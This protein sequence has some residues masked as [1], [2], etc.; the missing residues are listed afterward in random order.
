MN[1]STPTTT[2]LAVRL[3]FVLGAALATA[4]PV[5]AQQTPIVLARNVGTPDVVLIDQGTIYW[6]DFVTGQIRSVSKQPGG[7]VTLYPAVMRSGGDLAQD[8]ASLYFIG[9][10]EADFT[11]PLI[12][13]SKVGGLAITFG[14]AQGQSRLAMRPSGGTVYYE[15]VRRDIPHATPPGK[16]VAQWPTGVIAARAAAGGD[17][18]ALLW[19]S[20]FLAADQRAA[21]EA[22]A[23]NYA[24]W[25]FFN[26]PVTDNTYLYWV[27]SELAS[28]IWRMPL[29][30]GP[31]APFISGRA[32]PSAIVAPTQGAAAG[33]LFWLELDPQLTFNRIMRRNVGGQI[34]MLIDRVD[35]NF[36]VD[37]DQIFCEQ[38]GRLMQV[39]IDGGTPT[40][41]A[42][43]SVAHA[44]QAIAV[45]A[46]YVYWSTWTT[47]EIM[48]LP[49]SGS[50]GTGGDGPAAPVIIVHPASQSAA[51]GAN[52]SFT[53]AATGN[54]A[55]TF[56]WQTASSGGAFGEIAGATSTTLNV[57]NVTSAANANQYRAI[58]TNALGSATSNAATLTVTT[59]AGG[60]TF[61]LSTT[62]AVFG[63]TGGIGSVTVTP[64]ASSC[65]WTAASNAG[66]LTITAG[67]SG[68]GPGTVSY[69]ISS[70][71]RGTR[72]AM[73]VAGGQ[74]LTVTQSSS[75]LSGCSFSLGATSAT[76]ALPGGTGIVAVTA[77]PETCAWTA[78]SNSAFIAVTAG[79]A[80]SG[81]RTVTYTVNGAAGPRAGTLTIAGQIFS[82][83]QGSASC[84]LTISPVSANFEANA[85]F[86]LTPDLGSLSVSA[87]APDCPW[88]AVSNSD[89]LAVVT[90]A[91][92][93]GSGTVGYTVSPNAAGTPKL[94]PPS[95]TGTLTVAGR[96]FTIAQ[97]GTLACT[98]VVTPTSISAANTGGTYSAA[99]SATNPNTDCSWTA[100]SHDSW[101]TILSGSTGNLN[102]P[103]LVYSASNTTTRSR[104][105]TLTIAG[106]TVTVVQGTEP[107][108][109]LSRSALTFSASNRRRGVYFTHACATR[110]PLTNRHRHGDVD[111]DIEQALV[112]SHPR[113][114]NGSGGADGRDH[115]RLIGRRHR[116]ADGNDHAEFCRGKYH[117]S[118]DD[119][120]IH[121]V[122]G[123]GR[124]AAAGSR[125]HTGG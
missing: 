92:G 13:M 123:R 78:V 48:R 111:G 117:G 105:G 125:R 70:L 60:C 31:A 80:G 19:N 62:A 101:L 20:A 50:T 10:P 12:R 41:L 99:V 73:L 55:P 8:N 26:S 21:L 24:A 5:A 43:A 83:I 53:V 3:G 72:L 37:G 40:V 9:E 51:L 112:E 88:T 71:D 6:S 18:I 77:S 34:T 33:S 107:V 7:A 29:A 54:P 98:Y 82:V 100:V 95:R 124:A 57:S 96:T 27:G 30:G 47:G 87:S 42:D 94:N 93:T 15:G 67:A 110:P 32:F 38:G 114:R 108:M 85:F 68:T 4:S 81:T 119:R 109:T 116:H 56:Q 28:D 90:G 52:L 122:S 120:S 69:A 97:E 23:V 76:F 14:T 44:P 49:R 115:L 75:D 11:R 102:G 86:P 89:F 118:L 104:I 121:R 66:F 64:S 35:S 36:A 46:N 65:A 113:F 61:T 58:A 84:S 106:Q 22:N 45:D 25:S 17:E 63:A 74:T 103:V 79:S 1:D 2:R 59:T 39:S 91:A 16:P